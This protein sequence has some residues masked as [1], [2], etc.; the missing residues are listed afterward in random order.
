MINQL[1]RC[2]Y[3]FPNTGTAFVYKFRLQVFVVILDIFP[4]PFFDAEVSI[5]VPFFSN[6]SRS[7]FRRGESFKVETAGDDINK[8]IHLV[9][10]LCAAELIDQIGVSVDQVVVSLG[11]RQDG[12]YGGVPR[13]FGQCQFRVLDGAETDSGGNVACTFAADFMCTLILKCLV[14]HEAQG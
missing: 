7:F 8:D 3:P 2:R 14:L 4:G 11:G 5:A 6:G 10:A 12:R 1:L 9:F 13:I